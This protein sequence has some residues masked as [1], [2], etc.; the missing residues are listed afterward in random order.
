MDAVLDS[1]ETRI[2]LP[3]PNALSESMKDLYMRHLALSNRQ[4]NLIAH[5]EKKR[6]YYYAY[7]TISV[8]FLHW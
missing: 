2:L 3:N 6:E 7:K 1:C 4:V 5:A 8:A